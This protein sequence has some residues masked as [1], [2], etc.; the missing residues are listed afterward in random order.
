M[1]GH[2]FHP[3]T[4]VVIEKTTKKV[5]GWRESKKGELKELDDDHRR[6]CDKNGW[7]Y[8]LPDKDE[9]EEEF[10]LDDE[11]EGEEDDEVVLHSGG[12]EGGSGSDDGEEEEL[13][14]E[15][16]SEFNLDDE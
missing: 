11:V 1:E 3:E 2:G 16:E 7:E 5:V 15:D 8:D 10:V 4:G 14:L 6:V 12:D 9:E 13:D